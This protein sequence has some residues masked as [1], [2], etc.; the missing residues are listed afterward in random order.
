MGFSWGGN[1]L[2]QQFYSPNLSLD[3]AT[4]LATYVI[5][6]VS[7]VDPSVSPFE[8]ESCYFRIDD[9]KLAVGEITKNTLR[10][11]KSEYESRKKLLRYV[12][13]Q[14]NNL[15][16]KEFYKLIKQQIK[17]D[18]MKKSSNKESS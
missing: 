5:N 3:E 11:V 2:L 16:S 12:W 17:K 8:G 13:K 15:G 10:Q 4:K 7:I 9:G 1:L 6:E 14:S 18:K